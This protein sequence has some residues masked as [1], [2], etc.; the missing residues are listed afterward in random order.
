MGIVVE[1]STRE[2]LMEHERALI[3]EMED[4]GETPLGAAIMLMTICESV[5]N[6]MGYEL[7]MYL[8]AWHRVHEEAK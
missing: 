8:R 5:K 2:E 4:A 3:K 1:I 6:K 7:A